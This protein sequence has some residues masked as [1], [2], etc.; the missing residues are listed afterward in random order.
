MNQLQTNP[1]GYRFQVK[2]FPAIMQGD[3]TTDSVIAA[4]E[5]IYE[6][7]SVFDVVVIIRGGGSQTDLGCFDS[8]EMAANIAQFP[9]RDCRNRSRERRNNR[10]PV[11]HICG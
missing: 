6:Y 11:L 5:R 3:K 7:E 1:Y 4:L 2:L 8:Y 10:R 9:L